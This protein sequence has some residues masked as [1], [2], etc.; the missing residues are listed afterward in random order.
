MFRKFIDAILTTRFI[1]F[2]L[3]QILEPVTNGWAIVRKDDP[4]FFVS[5]VWSFVGVKVPPTK[6][7]T[8][9]SRWKTW[10]VLELQP[11]S[12]KSYLAI[13]TFTGRRLACLGHAVRPGQMIAFRVGHEPG[14]IVFLVPI[15][16]GEL[17]IPQVLFVD[18]LEEP[19]L[20]A[21]YPDILRV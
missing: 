11:D 17:E 4:R 15:E 9:R 1:Q 20:K 19:D 21:N 16:G 3:A 14:K 6:I 18:R 5:D 8:R 2:L 10:M 12:P 7:T 13:D